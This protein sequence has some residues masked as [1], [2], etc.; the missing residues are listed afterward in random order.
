MDNIQGLFCVMIMNMS[1]RQQNCDI[2]NVSFTQR[3]HPSINS[4]L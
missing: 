4:S 2:K 1:L 3:V